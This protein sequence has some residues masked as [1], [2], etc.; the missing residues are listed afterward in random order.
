[1]CEAGIVR[2]KSKFSYIIVISVLWESVGIGGRGVFFL[3]MG[4]N[5]TLE[6]KRL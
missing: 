3:A 4:C 2:W 6:A 5:Q 1:M